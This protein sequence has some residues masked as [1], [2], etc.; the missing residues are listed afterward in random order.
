MGANST[1]LKIYGGLVGVAV[2]AVAGFN[3]IVDPRHIFRLVDQ[4]GFNHYKPFISRQGASRIKSL[5][6]AKDQGYDGVLLGNS[7]IFWGLNPEAPAFGEHNFYNAGIKSISIYQLKKIFEYAIKHQPIETAIIGLNLNLFDDRRPAIPPNQDFKHS[8]FNNRPVLISNLS[9]AF[10]RSSLLA[11]LWT[12]SYN[13][14]VKEPLHRYTE[15]GFLNPEYP[16]PHRTKNFIKVSEKM[17]N[18][19][20]PL[21]FSYNEDTLAVFKQVL[22]LAA[23]NQIKLILF[24]EPGHALA[25]KWSRLTGNYKVTESW[26]GDVVALLEES[27]V[28]YELWDFTGFNSVT[29]ELIPEN[30]EIE[31]KYFIDPIHYTWE[32]GDLIAARL[33]GEETPEGFGVRLTP[34]NLDAQLERNLQ[35]SED[36]QL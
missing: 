36:Y 16:Q 18:G 8:A 35:Q 29:T 26:K 33:M 31:L 4:V 23:A 13:R 3:L 20:Y 22:D 11:S 14:N 10:T 24:I 2:A 15:R 25:E 28:E 30:E 1:Y 32:T 6:L 34:E 19:K 27:A 21:T 12:L 7:R 5:E 17:K 9:Q